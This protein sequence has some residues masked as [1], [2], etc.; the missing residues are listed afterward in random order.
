[1]S[2]NRRKLIQKVRKKWLQTKIDKLNQ[3]LSKFLTRKPHITL[4]MQIL[5]KTNKSR[6]NRTKVQKAI[7]VRPDMQVRATNKKPR[8]MSL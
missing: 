7:A 8:R 2:K 1:M 3:M 6:I 5:N 4:K